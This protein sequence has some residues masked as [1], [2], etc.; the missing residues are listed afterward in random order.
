MYAQGLAGQLRACPYQTGF[1][2]FTYIQK[3][4]CFQDGDFGKVHLLLPL[5]LAGPIAGCSLVI[6]PVCTNTERSK[7]A[8]PSSHN[9]CFG[10]SFSHVAQSLL[11]PQLS[12][13]LFYWVSRQ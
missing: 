7:A 2:S 4:Q 5:L 6:G 10:H 11:E 9:L 12:Q 1:G 13:P 3:V 8:T